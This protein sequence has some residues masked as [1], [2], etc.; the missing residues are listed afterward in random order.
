MQRFA[1]LV[2][3]D[4]TGTWK[5][6]DRYPDSQARAMAWDAFTRLNLLTPD[7][8]GAERGEY[9]AIPA[10][11]FDD[12]AR[13]CFGE[14]RQDLETRLRAGI[15]HS[16]L[17]SHLAK[18]R[19]LVPTLALLNH[20]ADVGYGPIGEVSVLRS[21]AFAEYLESHAKRAY[22]SGTQIEAATAKTILSRIRKGDLSD[23]FTARDIHQHDWSNLTDKEQVGAG[24]D[25][26]DDLGW[27]RGTKSTTGGRPKIIYSINPRASR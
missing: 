2:W 20:L 9:D 16:A 18:Y 27:V 1:L 5:E 13:G 25:L 10:L 21:I 23:Q 22:G 6:V 4:D 7:Q 11:R 19:K 3:P 17:E 8:A 12:R 24:L 15:M 14:W 26:L